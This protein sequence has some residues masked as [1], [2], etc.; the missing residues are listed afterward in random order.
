MRAIAKG[1]VFRQPAAAQAVCAFVCV[2]DGAV[3]I[4]ENRRVLDQIWPIWFGCDF[5]ITL[6]GSPIDPCVTKWQEMSIY[7]VA[8][9]PISGQALL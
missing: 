4:F 1:F 9:R 7:Q 8:R 2:D 5:Y 3:A 6:L